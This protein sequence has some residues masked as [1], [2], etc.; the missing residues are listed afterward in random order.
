MNLGSGSEGFHA[1]VLEFCARARPPPSASTTAKTTGAKRGPNNGEQDFI[2]GQ[3]R[4]DVGKL[5][6]ATGN[7]TAHVPGKGLDAVCEP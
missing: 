5:N 7:G 2:L 4:I 1:G 6:E 3:D